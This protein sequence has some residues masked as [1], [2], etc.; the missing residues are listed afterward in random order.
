MDAKITGNAFPNRAG[1]VNEKSST[2][3]NLNDPL[4][5]KKH[6]GDQGL[7]QILNKIS[8]PNYMAKKRRVVGHGNADLDKDAFFK[9]M[10]TQMKQQDPTNPLKSHEMAAQLAQFSSVEQLTNI[11]ETL[12]GMQGK[13]DNNKFDVLNLIGKIVS[14]DS[15]FIDRK[16][17]DK[18]HNIEFHLPEKAD[19]VKI[20]IKDDK[21][22]LVKQYELKDLKKGKNQVLWNGMHGDDKR[23]AKVG[24]YTVSIDAQGH[25]KKLKADT[26][27]HGPV[28]G[29]KFTEKGPALVV[30][31]KTLN[32]KDIREIKIDKKQKVGNLKQTN[33]MNPNQK[34]SKGAEVEKPIL[35]N[36]DTAQMDQSLRNTLVKK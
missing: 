27:F 14:G 3:K 33:V 17:G 21:G 4:E 10:L 28:E 32:L 16:K 29:V 2:G 26:K 1:I 15:A 19:M 23:D 24:Q 6:F 13:E 30:N 12:K 9:L 7:D 25:G 22:Q 20:K 5:M 35:A 11:N 36:L 31:G 34:L 8:D 18:D